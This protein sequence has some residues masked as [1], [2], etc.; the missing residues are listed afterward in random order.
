MACGASVASATTISAVAVTGAFTDLPLTTIT[1]PSTAD[2]S[3][4]ILAGVG[5]V[6]FGS[7]PLTLSSVS[8]TSAALGSHAL[9]DADLATDGFQFSLAGLMAGSYALTISG[10]TSGGLGLVGGSY[11]ISPI[12]EPQ[13]VALFLAGLGAVGLLT[14][15]RR[16]SEV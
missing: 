4:E 13:S 16:K 12:P 14:L 8:F 3:G 15:R 1:V 7:L 10:F 9:T 2:V 11:G 6:F 5:T